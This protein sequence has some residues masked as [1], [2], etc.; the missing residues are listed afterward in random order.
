MKR[1]PAII[2][3]SQR[4]RRERTRGQGSPLLTLLLNY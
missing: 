3:Y 1:M 2:P 4:Q